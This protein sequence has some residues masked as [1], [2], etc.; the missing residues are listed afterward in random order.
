MTA[1]KVT[2]VRGLSVIAVAAFLGVLGGY[3]SRPGYG[4]SR[5]VLLGVLGTVAVVGVAGV[6]FE[7]PFVAAGG[8]CVLMLM[9]FWQAVLWVYIFPVAGVLVVAAVVLANHEQTFTTV[10][11]Q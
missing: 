3:L 4:P 7:R 6:V 8:A 1:T 11:E 10:T 5:L 2:V 9:G